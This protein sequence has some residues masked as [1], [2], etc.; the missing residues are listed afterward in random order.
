MKND[1][2]SLV[3]D[4]S[5][6]NS[7]KKMNATCAITYNPNKSETINFRFFDMRTTTGEHCSK[8]GV[9]FDA[10]NSALDKHE[11]LWNNCVIIGLDNWKTNMGQHN[12][13]KSRVFQNNDSCFIA[14]C[15]CH[16]A[17]LAAQYGGKA[18]LKE[19]GFSV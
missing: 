15:G 4:G 7:I 6:D 19:T 14:G 5:N 11:I 17:H 12:S 2:F 16:L 9:L 10:I 3:N 8:S 1:F 18:F 13:I